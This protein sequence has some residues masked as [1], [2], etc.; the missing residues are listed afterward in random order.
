M[1]KLKIFRQESL[2]I[3]NRVIISKDS[4]IQIRNITR[5]WHGRP[6]VDIPILN[7]VI[8][9]LIGVAVLST[10]FSAIGWLV[11]IATLLVI[12]YYVY[13]LCNYTLN[14]ELSSGEVYAFTSLDHEFIKHSYEKVKE[15]MEN[16][17]M[18]EGKYEINFNS[19]KIDI[20]KGDNNEIYKGSQV[21]VNKGDNS[22]QHV[23]QTDNS[24]ENIVNSFNTNVEINYEVI[25]KELNTLLSMP[26]VQSQKEDL[27]Y[28]HEAQKKAEEKD[29]DG[30][31]N[32]LKKLSHK[33]MQVIEVSSSLLTIA[34]FI[35]DFL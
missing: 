21:V 7:L 20:V 30:L 19:C 11:I 34:G 31:K 35:K 5:I 3:A 12:A 29:T 16:K 2:V 15:L 27:E 9:L 25:S 26:E 33:T 14:F 24:Q 22:I 23:N 1:K 13:T 10:P 17:D 18:A 4:F 28:I 6:E 8:A 32:A